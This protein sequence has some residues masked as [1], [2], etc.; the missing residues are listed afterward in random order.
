MARLV[1]AM[2][3]LCAPALCV[4][5]RDIR[6]FTPVFDGLLR[7][8][9]EIP[10]AAF[11][12]AD[13]RIP[14]TQ[15]PKMLYGVARPSQSTPRTNPHIGIR[16]EWGRATP[17]AARG[18]YIMTNSKYGVVGAAGLALMLTVASASAQQPAPTRVRGTI[19]PVDGNTL[20]VKSREGAN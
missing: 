13:C 12:A 18:G 17:R 9:D 10:V 5:G 2:T 4:D 19:A 11:V 20:Q 14:S 15:P 8:H 7:G 3:P 16:F 1:P 6:A